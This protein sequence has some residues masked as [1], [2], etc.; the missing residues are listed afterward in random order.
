MQ[1]GLA[2]FQGFCLLKT[3]NFILKDG[4][5]GGEEGATE[6]CSWGEGLAN[7]VVGSGGC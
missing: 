6:V 2:V 7:A 1:S 5:V 4:E 3:L